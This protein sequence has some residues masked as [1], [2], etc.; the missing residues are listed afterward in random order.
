VVVLVTM[1]VDAVVDEVE[2]EVVV[3]LMATAAEADAEE[4]VVTTRKCGTLL[5]SWVVS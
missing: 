2:A 5:P 1:R 3:A 4:V